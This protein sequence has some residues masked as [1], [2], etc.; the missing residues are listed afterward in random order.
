MEAAQKFMKAAGFPF[1][2]KLISIN[3][4]EMLVVYNSIDRCFCN[5][6][7]KVKTYSVY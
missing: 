1:L 3:C 6:N 4:S 2:T 5:I 7:I